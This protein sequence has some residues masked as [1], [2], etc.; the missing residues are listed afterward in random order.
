MTVVDV[1]QQTL[2]AVP[3]A[4]IQRAG[5]VLAAVTGVGLPSMNGIWAESAEPDEEVVQAALGVIEARGVPFSVQLRPGVPPSLPAELAGLGLV[6]EDDVPLMVLDDPGRLE[7]ALRPD[8]LQ[9]R[10][11][12]PSEAPLHA[13][14]VAAGFEAPEEVFA[15]LLTPET[16]GREGIRVYLGEV[17][18]I[19][20]VTGLGLTVGPLVGI[21]NIATTPSCRGRG[22]GAAV[23]A[24]AILDGLDAGASQAYLQ[25][26]P[27]GHH[28]YERLGFATL[29]RWECWAGAT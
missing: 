10:Q 6:R 18:G 21:F 3:G 19:P 26:S 29:E 12:E 1:F 8:G 22:Y 5:G 2:E 15:T 13:H 17:G 7:A 25:S 23:T 16:I 24:R 27:A 20:A 14:V 9:L 28:L 11:L 4:W